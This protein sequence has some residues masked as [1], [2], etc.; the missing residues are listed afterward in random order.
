MPHLT[1]AASLHAARTV[2]RE[3]SLTVRPPESLP[4]GSI[5]NIRA[6]ESCLAITI[7]YGTNIFHVSELRPELR[8]WQE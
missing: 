6:D 5:P 2:L 3:F 8:Y 4:S 1:S 7:D